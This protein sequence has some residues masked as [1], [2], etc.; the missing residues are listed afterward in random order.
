MAMQWQIPR[1]PSL[2]PHTR[3]LLLSLSRSRSPIGFTLCLLSEQ[4]L[5]QLL[6]GLKKRKRRVLLFSTSVQSL[7]IVQASPTIFNFPQSSALSYT[8]RP[9]FF[10]IIS[11]SS[12]GRTSD[13]MARCDQR[14]VTCP[15]SA[16]KRGAGRSRGVRLCFYCRRGRAVWG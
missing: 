8:T 13:W 1:Y 11:H 3:T 4:V 14:S 12:A 9:N 10:R 5:E 15:L 7:D 2:L 16:F 6:V